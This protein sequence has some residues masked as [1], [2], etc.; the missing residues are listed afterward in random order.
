M[1]IDEKIVMLHG[2]KN[3]Y[4]GCVQGNERLGIPELKYEDGPQ[5]FRN[6]VVDGSST[7]FPSSLTIAASFDN[8]TAYNWGIC[9][10]INI[11]SIGK[12]MGVE[13]FNK[14]ANV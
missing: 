4:T 12:A 13:F 14:G 2:C 3:N 6:K 10:K 7:A 5:G 1:T 9:K 11:F 8:E